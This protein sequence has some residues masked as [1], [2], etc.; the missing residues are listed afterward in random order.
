MGLVN[1]VLPADEHMSGVVDYARDLADNV[2]P[3]SIRI[4]KRQI[5]EA[6]MQDL[7]EAVRRANAEMFESFASDDFREGVAHY[8]EKRQAS[9]TGT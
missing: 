8:V 7:S 3:R 2:S 1:Q 6:L 9:F 4:M 5:Y